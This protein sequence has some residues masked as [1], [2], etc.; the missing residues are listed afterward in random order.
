MIN[1]DGF[2]TVISESSSK[3]N[4]RKFY[5]NGYWIKL[6]NDRCN[7]GLAEE[8]VSKFENLI[9]DFPYV[10]YKTDLFSLDGDEY[11]GC[12]CYNMYDDKDV[13]FYSLRHVL[14]LNN[15]PLSIFTK[16][17]DIAVNMK[18][19]IN[20][21]GNKTGVDITMYLFR[22]LLLDVL[23]INED[24]HYMNLGICV[25]GNTAAQAPCFD[26]GASLF[27]TNWT[28]RKT[29]S[30]EE[31][32]KMALG[33]ARPFS[34]F[35]TKQVEAC[36]RLG[37]KPLLI[38][39]KGLDQLMIYYHNHLYDDNMNNIIKAVLSDRLAYY[40]NKGVYEFV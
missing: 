5:H 33:T 25:K 32:M 4:Q 27:C 19:V 9:L 14:K 24:R 1:L 23:I 8:F 20:V 11:K 6:D 15:I 12:Y 26:N 29:R 22:L 37:A 10:E 30:L 17:E 39:K 13:V 36:I 2:K 16:E 35:Y 7:E 3:G 21:I 18:N 38:D 40:Y 34:K 31:N 28:Y